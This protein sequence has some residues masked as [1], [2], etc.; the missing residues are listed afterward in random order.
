MDIVKSIE[1]VVKM[2][3]ECI[4]SFIEEYDSFVEIFKNYGLNLNIMPC[5]YYNGKYHTHRRI[6]GCFLAFRIHIHPID[7]TY[8]QSVEKY[9]YKEFF[10][11]K[12]LQIKETR[13]GF[14]IQLSSIKDNSLG[15]FLRRY[16]TKAKRANQT[17]KNTQICIKETIG[18]VFF[19]YIYVYRYRNEIKKTYRG[20]YLGWFFLVIVIV[21][22]AINQYMH[23]KR[24]SWDW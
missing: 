3:R 20:F 2:E 6:K 14:K 21:L 24:L 18:D 22:I 16:I 5:Y 15:M 17:K 13:N 4:K 1:D 8:N 9:F 12:I 23:I 11:K 7:L 10:S 19:S